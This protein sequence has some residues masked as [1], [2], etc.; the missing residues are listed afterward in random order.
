[1]T[2]RSASSCWGW[3]PPPGDERYP[4]RF[5]LWKLSIGRDDGHGHNLVIGYLERKIPAERIREQERWLH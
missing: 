5:F 2:L 3:I 4:S 1:M